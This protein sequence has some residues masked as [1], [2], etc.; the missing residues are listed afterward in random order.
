MNVQPIF[1]ASYSQCPNV[2]NNKPNNFNLLVIES[3]GVV[4]L[5]LRTFY[6]YS[7]L[8]LIS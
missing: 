3:K 8:L 6:C 2:N 7:M 5:D 4:L 1:Y